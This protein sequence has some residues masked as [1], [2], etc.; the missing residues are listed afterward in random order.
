MVVV[1]TR[2]ILSAGK[3]HFIAMHLLRLVRDDIAFTLLRHDMPDIT[4]LRLD[5][6]RDLVRLVT[7]LPVLENRF[8]FPFVVQRVI[9]AMRVDKA[10]VQVHSDKL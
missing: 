6:I 7:V 8:T 2:G 3:H 1:V 4:L 5:V 9:Y 10:A